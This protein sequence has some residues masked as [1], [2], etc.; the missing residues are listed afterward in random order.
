MLA[1]N[2]IHDLS[3]QDLTRASIGSRHM[4]AAVGRSVGDG[5]I[6][7]WYPFFPV[8]GWAWSGT[9]HEKNAH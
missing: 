7:R 9:Q 2:E 6:V 1:D 3:V 4:H 8:V 5:A